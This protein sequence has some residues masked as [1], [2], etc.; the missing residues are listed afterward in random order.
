MRI[1]S[2]YIEFIDEYT[3]IRPTY[4]SIKCVRLIAMLYLVRF[5]YAEKT[6]LL[7][8]ENCTV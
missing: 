3:K 2:Y 7:F 5:I 4:L 6:F 1:Q 8:T